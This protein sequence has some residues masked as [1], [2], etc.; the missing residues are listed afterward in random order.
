MGQSPKQIGLDPVIKNKRNSA[1]RSQA[2]GPEGSE[3][4]PQAGLQ[5]SVGHRQ[6]DQRVQNRILGFLM[7][8][9]L[10]PWD[11]NRHTFQAEGFRISHGYYNP[12]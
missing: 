4:G 12:Y 8:E 5:G 2:E 9:A 10:M 7:P 1:A 11:L 3:Q 6:K